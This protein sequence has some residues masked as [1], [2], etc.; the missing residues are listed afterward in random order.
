MKDILNKLRADFEYLTGEDYTGLVRAIGMGFASRLSEFSSKLKFIEKQAFAS[1]ADKDYL[2]LH[3]G[4]LVP[5]KAVSIAKGSVVFTG[6][7]G[8]VIPVGTR[9]SDENNTYITTVR[10]VITPRTIVVIVTSVVGN[11]VTATCEEGMLNRVVIDGV[12]TNVSISNG[13]II[14]ES[15][16][17]KVGDQPSVNISDSSAINVVATSK[18]DSSNKPHGYV[19]KLS[20]TLPGI[21]SLCNSYEISGGDDP[22]TLEQYRARVLHSL[23]QPQAPFN[24]AHIIHAVY[25]AVPSIKHIWIKGGEVAEGVVAVYA[26]NS[27][28]TLTSSERN[29]ITGIL[30]GMRPAQM[31]PDN[32]RVTAP[33]IHN[34]EVVIRDIFPADDTMKNEVT[35]NVETLF[36]ADLFEKGI[37]KQNIESVIYRTTN[38]NQRVESFVVDAGQC[39]PVTAGFWKLTGVK[40]T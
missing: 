15:T 26:L 18:G 9:L 4:Q 28:L 6:S 7:S 25:D 23:S 40:F 35:K 32:I 13:N 11:I 1:T 30:D 38:G 20:T 5:P 16:K 2:Y 31:K 27:K 3:S 39:S 12:P 10:G 19:L 21:D 22:E 37:T 8:A 29:T 33:S 17:Y 14:F 34:T 36:R 24:V